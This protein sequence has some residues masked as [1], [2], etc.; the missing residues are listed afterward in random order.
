MPAVRPAPPAARRPPGQARR[1]SVPDEQRHA[2]AAEP[3]R[4]GQPGQRRHG[5]DRRRAARRRSGA[6]PPRPWQRWPRW[7]AATHAF[8]STGAKPACCWPRTR[9][10]GWRC[11]TSC[12]PPRCRSWSSST[13]A[14]PTA[15]IRRGCGT[16]PSSDSAGRLVVASGERSRDLAVRLRYAGVEHLHE[17]D[18]VAAILA[19]GAP[20]VD[21]VANYTS[22]QALRARLA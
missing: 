1:S 14:S 18:P 20:S 4:P 6:G 19:A 21:V 11:S 16:F 13:P 3:A 7:W 17:P 10:A 8:G 22:F 12:V 2:A 15:G 5:P 9:P